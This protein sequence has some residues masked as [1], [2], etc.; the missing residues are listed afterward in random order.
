MTLKF[1]NRHKKYRLRPSEGL[2]MCNE[3]IHG[4]HQNC[5]NFSM[6]FCACWRDKH[7]ETF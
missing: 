1:R 5:E 7:E 6:L 3:C 4:R 2:E